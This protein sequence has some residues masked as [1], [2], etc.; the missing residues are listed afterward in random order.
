MWFGSKPYNASSV[1]LTDQMWANSLGATG[2]SVGAGWGISI[3]VN[4]ATTT[5]SNEVPN[6][7]KNTHDYAGITFS[8]L[9]LNV[10]QNS[11]ALFRFGSASYAI[12]AN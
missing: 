1:S 12:Q 9:L 11:T 8:G 2:V 3:G 5:F 10:N 4:T 6:S 7:W